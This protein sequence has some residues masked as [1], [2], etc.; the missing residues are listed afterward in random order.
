MEKT[1]LKVRCQRIGCDATFSEDDNPDGSCRYHDSGPIFHDGTKEW[2][3][4]KKR[5]HDFSL[6]LEIPGCKTGKH[7]AVKQVIA[8]VKKNTTP[9]PTVVSSTNASSK[10]SCS[11]CRQGFFC[12]EHGSQ[13]KP[14]SIVDKSPNLVG[15]A[16]AVNNSNVQAPKPKKIVDINEPQTCKNKGCGQTF[17]EKDNHDTACSYHPGPA[18][19]HDRMRGWKCCDIHVKEFD[20]FMNI[21]PCTKGWHSADPES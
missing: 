3:C 13:S 1:T 4:C 19:F 16:S 2:S 6:F 8:P 11:R 14:V 7:T 9:S 12:S 15:D 21:P 17:K 20:E 5:S 10:D 18:V